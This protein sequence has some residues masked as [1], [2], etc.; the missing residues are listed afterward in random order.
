MLCVCTRSPSGCDANSKLSTVVFMDLE[1]PADR[2]GVSSNSDWL[3]RVFKLGVGG[4]GRARKARLDTLFLVAD[5]FATL[6]RIF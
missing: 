4:A 5:P 3:P 2:K 1:E 6:R